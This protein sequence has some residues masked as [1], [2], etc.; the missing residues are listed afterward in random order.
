VAGSAGAPA[1]APPQLTK[2]ALV[3]DNRSIGTSRVWLMHEAGIFAKHGFDATLDF[4]QG[5]LATKAMATGQYEAGNASASSIVASNAEG[6]DIKI[7]AAVNTKIQYSLVVG[8]DITTVEQMRGKT[9][10]IARLGDSSDTVTRLIMRKLGLDPEHD[11]SILQV[12]NSP[13]RYAALLTG[14]IH[15]ML[16]DPMDVVRARKDGLNVIADQDELAI[17]YA[18]NVF[19]MRG[20]FIREQR[21]TAK[22][23]ALALAD[24]VRYYKTHEDEAVA[25]A[26]KYLQSDDV[27]SLRAGVRTFA[28]TVMPDKPLVTEASMRPILDEVATR[29][30]EV[31]GMPWERFV[32][33]S[34]LEELDRAGQLDALCC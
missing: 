15:G 7:V 17:D 30:P 5:T 6:V 18:G 14:N 28:R 32:D 21:D 31:R 11:I 9:F 33:N 25:V 24:G 13:E 1:V 12:G 4:A 34:L 2:L 8:R 10:G 16:A 19:V 26:G 23:L 3:Y 29:T 20:Q 27:E 22:R